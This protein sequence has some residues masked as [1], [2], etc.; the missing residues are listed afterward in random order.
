MQKKAIIPYVGLAI[1]ILWFVQ[2]FFDSIFSTGTSF[3][4]SLLTDIPPSELAFRLFLIAFVIGVSVF[5]Y[6]RFLRSTQNIE[7][8]DI[9]I[10]E[11]IKKLAERD[12]QFLLNFLHKIRTQL[13]NVLG[14]AD[15]IR[16]EEISKSDSDRYFGY[17]ETSKQSTHSAID[18]LIGTLKVGDAKTLKTNEDYLEIINWQDKKILI[19]EDVEMNFI[20]LK[21]VLD[22]TGAEVLWAKDGNEVLKIFRKNRDV[23][24]IL[25]DILMPEMDGFEATKSIRKFDTEVP[26]IAQTAYNFDWTAIQKEGLGFDDFISKPIG[27]YDLILKTY[28]YLDR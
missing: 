13:N 5:F 4:E 24:L 19:A 15:L 6:L 14:F 27:H 20:L 16:D 1:I 23:N 2:A 12:P 8:I 17:I 21:A 26:I 11:G 9:E 10:P 18:E 25:M 3:I 22:K 28:R 7:S